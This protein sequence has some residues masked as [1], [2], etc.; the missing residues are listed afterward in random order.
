MQAEACG[1]IADQIIEM[2]LEDFNEQEKS[3]LMMILEIA[4]GILSKQGVSTV[5]QY[6]DLPLE[7]KGEEPLT[8][9]MCGDVVLE[10]ESGDTDGLAVVE[11]GDLQEGQI[12]MEMIEHPR[13]PVSW[14]LNGEITQDWI[15]NL[16]E[17]FKWFSWNKSPSEF[18]SVMPFTVVEQLTSKAS[19]ILHQ[20]SNCVKIQ[21]DKDTKV[22]VVGDLRGQ[23]LDLLNIWEATGLPSEKEFFVFN[24]NYVD[25]SLSS[26]DLFLVLLA[27]KVI[28]G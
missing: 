6:S 5:G 15:T 4:R 25:K 19:Q 13:E 3:S 23:Y 26:L 10:L 14:P 9:E 12:G 11:Q 7:L 17:T 8:V 2:S 21:C 16:M 18:Q 28:F 24:G 1:K 20:E 27:W 22:V